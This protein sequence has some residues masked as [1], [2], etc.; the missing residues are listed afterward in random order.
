[1]QTN[2]ISFETSL[3]ARV[4]DSIMPFNDALENPLIFFFGRGPSKGVLKSYAHS[5]WG[6]IFHRFGFPGL[7][8][9]IF[10]IIGGIRY[11]IRGLPRSNSTQSR[12]FI[13]L[14]LFCITTWGCF[15][16]AEDIFKDPQI[17]SFN[18]FAL[19]ILYN[20]RIIKPLNKKNKLKYYFHKVVTSDLPN[21]LAFKKS[22]INYDNNRKKESLS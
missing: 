20:R 18:M 4:R 13:V 9:Y 1:M 16:N 21:N 3:H 7:F 5:D 6:W 19:G 10:F 8:C 22:N 11:A 2:T 12:I 17:M 15:A 14:S